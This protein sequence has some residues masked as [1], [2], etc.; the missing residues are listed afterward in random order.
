MK[1]KIIML[2]VSCKALALLD[3]HRLYH[4]T[5]FRLDPAIIA[6]VYILR[7]NFSL[8]STSL[9]LFPFSCLWLP[10]CDVINMH[11]LTFDPVVTFVSCYSS[12]WSLI[13]WPLTSWPLGVYALVDLWPCP[14]MSSLYSTACADLMFAPA[15]LWPFMTCASKPILL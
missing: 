6:S 14:V 7:Y 11:C 4:F 3:M 2:L 9:L 1:N 12:G 10:S 8:K 13:P 15:D 5:N